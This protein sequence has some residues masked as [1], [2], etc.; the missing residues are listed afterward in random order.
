MASFD[1]LEGRRHALATLGSIE[2]RPAREV[3]AGEVAAN[4]RAAWGDKP[5]EYAQG[6]RDVLDELDR[7]AR[8]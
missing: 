1:R 5:G 2:G 8:K 6:V 3:S 7:R 4:L